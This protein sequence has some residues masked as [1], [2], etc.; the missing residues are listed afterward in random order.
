MK[1]YKQTIY[2]KRCQ[3]RGIH[4]KVIPNFCFGIGFQICDLQVISDIEI[5]CVTIKNIYY[6]Y[7]PFGSI[8]SPANKATV[9]NLTWK[10]IC[11]FTHLT[12]I[13]M[14]WHCFLNRL[15]YELSLRE[16]LLHLW[17][18]IKL[19]LYVVFLSCFFFVWSW[20]ILIWQICVY[21]FCF[22]SFLNW[23]Q[24]L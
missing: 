14:K 18:Y 7:Y 13:L 19:F 22:R 6:F 23:S 24:R 2:I 9:S 4:V 5:I 12:P 11:Y 1:Q 8:K 20:Y 3:F 21:S 15:I 10:Y 16:I 17:I